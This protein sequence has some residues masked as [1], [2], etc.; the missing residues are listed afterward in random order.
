MTTSAVARG[1]ACSRFAGGASRHQKG[2]A[3]NDQERTLPFATVFRACNASRIR[4]PGCACVEDE[5]ARI[6]VTIRRN[7]VF[8]VDG[9]ALCTRAVKRFL[10]SSPLLFSNRPV[11]EG[12]PAGLQKG[13]DDIGEHARGGI[14]EAVRW[15]RL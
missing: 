2:L 7:A 11:A 9:L 12:Q 3:L 14:V 13:V 6:I 10:Y 1:D 15:K 4:I 8:Q 5:R